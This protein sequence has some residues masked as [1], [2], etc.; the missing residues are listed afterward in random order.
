MYFDV[1]CIAENGNSSYDTYTSYCTRG[2]E[3]RK[4]RDVIQSYLYGQGLYSH[5]A[6]KQEF[7]SF[8]TGIEQAKAE[9]KDKVKSEMYKIKGWV[10]LLTTKSKY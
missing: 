5:E 10:C 3:N 6:F 2:D 9:F 4:C 7:K 8:T 1:K